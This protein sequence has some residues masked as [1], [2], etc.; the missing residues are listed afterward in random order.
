MM[1]DPHPLIAMAGAEIFP[2]QAC[3]FSDDLFRRQLFVPKFELMRVRRFGNDTEPRVLSG[4]YHLLN[5]I[6]AVGKKF[7]F[8]EAEAFFVTFAFQFYEFIAGDIILGTIAGMPFREPQHKGKGKYHISRRNDHKNVVISHNI[9]FLGMIIQFM[10]EFHALAKFFA[11]CVVNND[12]DPSATFPGGIGKPE[13]AENFEKQR[14]CQHTDKFFKRIRILPKQIVKS[15]Q[16]P[17]VPFGKFRDRIFLR[18]RQKYERGQPLIQPG[19]FVVGKAC[20]DN[21]GP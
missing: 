20:A 11:F 4:F 15:A 21:R 18:E 7:R 16:L 1:P 3:D 9:A 6:G 14:A 17:T 12:S 5:T 19:G 10:Y 8:S 2:L 13:T